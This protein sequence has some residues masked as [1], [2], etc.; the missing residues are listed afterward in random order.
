MNSNAKIAI[1]WEGLPFYAARLIRACIEQ[2]GEDIFVI[3]SKPTVPIKGMEESL[4]Q[5]IHWIDGSQTYSWSRLGITAP[6]IFIQ[7]GWKNLAFNDLGLEVRQQNGQVVGMIDNSWKNSPRQW[8]GAFV[9][10]CVYRNWFAAVWVPGESGEKL[11]RFLG[12]PQSK[13]YQGLYVADPNIF[14]RGLPLSQREKKFLFVGQL[15]KRKGIDLLV[16]AF[17]QFYPQFPD[18]Q[19]HIIGNGILYDSIIGEGIFKEDFKQPFE[20][21][22][23]MRQS[24]YLI[25]PSQEDHWALVIHEATLSGC[26][27]ITTKMVGSV[28][29]FVSAQNGIIIQK[30]SVEDLCEAMVKVAMLSNAELDRASD[31]SLYL[32]SKFSPERSSRDFVK[33]INDLRNQRQFKN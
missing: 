21:S 6:E 22:E 28:P 9:F 5:P 4:G 29:E 2:L 14:S 33:L 31:T 23:V 3:G 32:A 15:I 27:I 18:W 25:L 8:L 20:V 16:K 11:C 24:R 19:L 12:M 1:A 7:T 17:Q 30:N 26:G 13:I 10:R